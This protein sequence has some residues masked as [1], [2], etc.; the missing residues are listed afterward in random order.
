MDPMKF[1]HKLSYQCGTELFEY[2]IFTWC[3]DNFQKN[4]HHTY[5]GHGPHIIFRFRYNTDKVL[6]ILKW[7]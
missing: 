1:K 6:F 4:W 7:M 5:H 2:A 3:N